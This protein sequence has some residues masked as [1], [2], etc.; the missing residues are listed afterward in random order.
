MAKATPK[1]SPARKP[2]AKRTGKRRAPSKKSSH[3]ERFIQ[4][5]V[6]HGQAVKVNPGEKL[7]P[8][9]T[10]ELVEDE[11]GSVRVVR[12]RFSAL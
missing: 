1:R 4:S 7:P 8:G 10:H 9:A 3:A 11:D 6:A 12:K 5:L 2:A